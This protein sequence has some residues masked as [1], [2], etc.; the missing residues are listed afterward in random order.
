MKLETLNLLAFGPFTERVLSF[1]APGLHIVYGPNEA[2]K[3]SSLRALKA[4][5]YGIDNRSRDN[6]IH[7][8]NKLRVGATISNA[9]K[10]LEFVRRKGNKNT[11]LSMDEQPLDNQA[12]APFLNGVALR[13]SKHFLQ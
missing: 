7:A 4:L 1:D 11:L 3:S 8:N 10:R 5:F 2:G 12:L 9:G 13:F 6:F